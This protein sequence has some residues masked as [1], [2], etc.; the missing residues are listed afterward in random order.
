[1]IHG[2]KAGGTTA[3]T[4]LRV[5]LRRRDSVGMHK[6]HHWQDSKSAERRG[7]CGIEFCDQLL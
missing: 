2:L 4:Q 7:L 3:H 1:M 5:M 6:T